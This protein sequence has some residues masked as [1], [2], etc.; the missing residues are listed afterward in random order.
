MPDDLGHVRVQRKLVLVLRESLSLKRVGLGTRRC[1]RRHAARSVGLLQLKRSELVLVLTHDLLSVSLLLLRLRDAALVR[2]GGLGGRRVP[3][4][5]SHP[6]RQ[7]A[8]GA[9]QVPLLGLAERGHLG[10]GDAH[11]SDLGRVVARLKHHVQ[12]IDDAAGLLERRRRRRG[13]HAHRHGCGTQADAQAR[14]GASRA[15]ACGRRQRR[16]R[17]P[18][19]LVCRGCMVLRAL[20]RRRISAHVDLALRACGHLGACRYVR[21]LMLIRYRARGLL[22]ESVT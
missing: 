4:N 7:V 22:L 14:A 19:Q 8:D 12:V 18:I 6:A 20:Q 1:D 5:G 10:G 2:L 13:G 11:V 15:F 3:L 17:A 16:R 9:L 21:R